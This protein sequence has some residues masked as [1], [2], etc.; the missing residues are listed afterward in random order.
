MSLSLSKKLVVFVSAVF[1]LSI[2]PLLYIADTA[3]MR[4][5]AYA[6]EVNQAQIEKI[7]R[8]YL[9]DAARKMA[10][11]HDDLFFRVKTAA[12][13]MGSHLTR[14]YHTRDALVASPLYPDSGLCLNPENQMFVSRTDEPV[15]RAYW[16]GNTLADGVREEIGALSHYIPALI[17]SKALIKESLATHLITTSG[18]GYYHSL[19][20]RARAGVA[21]LPPASEFDLRDGAPFIAFRTS[22]EAVQD[23][24]WTPMYRDDV[25]DGLVMTAVAPV[26]GKDGRLAAVTGIDLPVE[27]IIAG[28]TDGSFLSGL[29][30][31]EH[32]FAFIQNETRGII[33]F[34][35]RFYPLFGINVDL[36]EFK[37]SADVCNIRLKDASVP[38]VRSLAYGRL[39]TDLKEVVLEGASY[40]VAAGNM[41]A[42]GWQVVLVVKKADLLVSV[43]KTAAELTKNHQVIWKDFLYHSLLSLAVSV[44]LALYGV[45]VFIKPI[46]RF[47]QTTRNIARGD[48]S[49]TL[50]IGRADEIGTL[51]RSL[52]LMVERLVASEQLKVKYT[53]KLEKEV[54]QR[55]RALEAANQELNRIKCQLETAVDQKTRQLKRL[56]EHLLNTG[57][58]ERKAI[59][60]DLHDSV[61][62]TLAFSIGKLKT[63]RDAGS[64][65]KADGINEVKGLLTR[66]INEIRL[67][68]YQL[69]PPVLDDFEIDV[70][71]GHLIDGYKNNGICV[72]S[73]LNRCSNGLRTSQTVRLNLYR[74]SNE[75]IVNI[76]KHSQADQAS[77]ELASR[78]NEVIVCVEDNGIGFDWDTVQHT[79]L[80]SLGLI[81]VSERIL[82]LG[83]RFDVRSSP[84]KGTRI[85]FSVPL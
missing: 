25:I 29:T 6:L 55:T 35:G 63:L 62:Q 60:S 58:N 54:A 67:I 1:L 2:A 30:N 82:H 68:I 22:R 73:Y 56:N 21:Q 36:A 14:I 5:G 69:R 50:S 51:S 74:A 57:E 80:A 18:I 31:A 48:F 44:I 40:L 42:V 53:D 26:Y 9:A 7:S 3:L 85:W 33:A 61:A 4:F 52:N 43:E 64:Q 8:H 10:Q 39:N 49:K 83:G 23:T 34:P 19:D 24:Q 77:L 72:I 20:P 46:K 76:L 45:K 16:G 84:G 79:K 66:A 59:A 17:R 11:A 71:L 27:G 81:S 70:A 38:Q 41:P 37:N 47:I 75:L 65:E 12:T 13:V 15:F 28:L 78:E 32:S